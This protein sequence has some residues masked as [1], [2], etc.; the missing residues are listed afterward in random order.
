M[1]MDDKEK[2]YTALQDLELLEKIR[3]NDDYAM[4][5]LVKRYANLVRIKARQYFLIGADHEDVTQ[6]GMIGLFKAIRDYNADNNKSFRGFAEMCI[7][8]QIISAIKMATRQKHIPL[9]TYISLSRPVFD[10]EG[11]TSL[12]EVLNEKMASN[13]EE[14]YIYKEQMERIQKQ[15]NKVLSKLET[16]VLQL[17]LEGKS[18]SEISEHLG[19]PTKS[20]D[21][22]LQRIKKKLEVRIGK[23]ETE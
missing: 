23:N 9:N 18:Y 7:V 5:V 1:K 6:E 22:A 12:M 21:N 8:R 16:N 19:K 13:P 20:I 3:A 14:T 17:Y 15:M 2:M 11:D 10:E 4:D